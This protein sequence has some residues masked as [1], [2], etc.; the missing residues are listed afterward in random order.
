MPPVLLTAR[1]LAARLDVSYEAVLAWTRRDEIPAIRDSRN[2]LLYNLDAVLLALRSGATTD[3]EGVE[4][5]P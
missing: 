4:V 1:E 2:R 3:P 5:A